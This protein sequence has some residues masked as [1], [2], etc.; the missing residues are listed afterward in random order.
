M[1][2]FKR[3]EDTPINEGI[4]ST[5]TKR[6]VGKITKVSDDGYGFITS[7]DIPFTRIFFHWTSLNQNTL[8]FTELRNGMEVE[9]TPIEVADKGWRAIRIE[10]LNESKE[11]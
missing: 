11:G 7:R 6:I 8:H 9:F 2:R 3:T 4:T 10:V 1:D 5:D